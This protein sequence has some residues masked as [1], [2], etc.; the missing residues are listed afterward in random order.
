MFRRALPQSTGTNWLVTVPVAKTGLDLIYREGFTL[1]VLG[2]QIVVHLRYLLQQ[3][4]PVFRRVLGVVLGDRFDDGVCRVVVGENDGLVFDQ[5]YKAPEL[6]LGTQGH[7]Y[8]NWSRLQS[9]YDHVDGSIK[10][11]ADTVH[12]VD[13]TYPGYAVL[14]GL[15]PDRLGLGL[16][17]CHG[18]EDHHTAVQHPQAPLH[19]GGEVNVAGGIDDVYRVFIPFTRCC[20]GGNGYAPLPLLVHPVHDGG[21]FVDLAHLVDAASVVEDPL[22][23]GGLAR[24]DMRDESDVSDSLQHR[25]AAAGLTIFSEG[26]DL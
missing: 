3:S 15:A 11:C 19:L 8:G 9:I 20:R 18:I 5:V 2:H 13:E 12:F 1:Q 24:V 22:G 4:F 26:L 6:R 10:V 17:A 7:L 16:D 21:A 23:D 25:I 14:V